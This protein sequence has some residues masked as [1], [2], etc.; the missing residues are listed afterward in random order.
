MSTP[1]RLRKTRELWDP[2]ARTYDEQFDHDIGSPEE[3]VAWE[4]IFTTL[5]GDRGNLRVLDIGTGTGFLAL[6]LAIQGHQVT[7]IDLSPEMLDLARAKAEGQDL[8][9]RF[10]IGD[11][12]DPPFPEQSFDLIISRH[13][14]WS[15]SDPDQTLRNWYHLLRP[16]GILAILDGDWCTPAPDD[17]DSPRLPT[18]NEVAARVQ[19][20]GFINVQADDLQDL[21]SSLNE[22]ARRDGRPIDHFQRYLVWAYRAA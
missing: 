8:N 18:S 12:E 9:V 22:R 6:R 19:D 14:F 13:V 7:A 11:A 3:G 16:E 17:P 15:M 2:Q 10:E 20:H 4:R 1:E 5:T 21:R